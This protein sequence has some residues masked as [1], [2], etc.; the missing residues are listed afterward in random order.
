MTL[1]AGV[2]DLHRLAL[3]RGD[4]S[5]G[6]GAHVHIRD[7]L[8]DLGHM[9]SNALAAGTPGGVMGVSFERCRPWTIW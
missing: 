1:V 3:R 4:K 2:R 6:V 5:K 7:R 9:A 8:L